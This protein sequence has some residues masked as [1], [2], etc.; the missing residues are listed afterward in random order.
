MRILVAMSGGVDSSV[1]AATMVERGHEVIGVTLKQWSG[2]DGR[3][4]TAGCCTVADAEDAR[5]VAAKLGIPY[6]V[7]DY[8]DRFAESVVAHFTSEYLAGRTP[9][10]CIE[11]NRRVRFGA[12]L[13]RA[14]ELGCDRLATGHH[15]RV[16]HDGTRYRLLVGRDR[17]KDQ[18]YVLHMLGQG[19]LAS[20]L[21]PIGEMTKTEVRAEA[22]RL[23]L[24][25]AT[26]ADSQDLC[27][28]AGDYREFLRERLPQAARPGPIVDATGTV[29]GSHRGT[30]DFTI[31]QR[32][33]LGVSFGEPRYVVGVDA[34][35]STVTIGRREELAVE[36]CLVTGVSFISGGAPE[37]GAEVA[38]KIRYRSAAV[39]A[40][41]WTENGGRRV[42]FSE[43]Q[44]AV[45][46]G[47]AAVFYRG[48]E[49][50]GGGTIE[51]A[52]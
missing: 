39:A 15:A 47:Q 49:V 37:E 34:A 23:G 52:A 10:P 18:S 2:P 44:L 29:V 31:G 6:Y 1:A 5:R 42:R 17:D 4:P 24:R 45:S 14:A 13:S 50:L 11:C 38:V 36:A 20:I 21:L 33:G 51:E 7:L 46:P 8:R 25:T 16:D 26:K 9:N 3:L 41:L 22:A 30:A 35:T 48:D 27:F 43:A 12:L 32:K 40:T 28:V 19:E